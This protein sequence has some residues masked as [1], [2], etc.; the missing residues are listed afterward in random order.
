MPI[1]SGPS[2]KRGLL[3]LRHDI[4]VH[5]IIKAMSATDLCRCWE[6]PTGAAYREGTLIH[7]GVK[8][9]ADISGIMRDG[10]RLEVEV[11]TGKAVQQDNQKAWGKMIIN[12]RGIYF[13]AR[14]VE[15]AIEQ[16]QAAANTSRV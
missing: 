14:S 4:L 1:G 13:V 9:S 7:Y 2:S 11:K 3:R 5:E 12:M 16:L 15:H 10:R 6:Q 8:G